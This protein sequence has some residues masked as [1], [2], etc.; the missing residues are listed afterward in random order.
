LTDQPA[1]EVAAPEAPPSAK[2]APPDFRAV[3]DASPQPLL[4]MAAD[5]PK[6]TMLAVN[7]AHARAF[8]TTPE[9]LLGW[10]VLEVFGEE[11]EPAIAPFVEAIRLSL[12]AV[13]ATRAP[14]QM[15]V[16]PYPV[17]TPD[18]EADE[19]YWSAVNAPVL[20]PD[21][22][23]IQI[24]SAVQDVTGEVLERRS[25]D[26]R[27]LLM[28]E[29]DHRARNALTVVQSFVR[30]TTAETLADFRKV[31]DGRVEALARAQTSLAARR[32]EGASLRDVIEGELAPL[33]E[34]D[35]YE[36][37]GP[38]VLLPPEH[39]QAMSMAIHELATNAAKYGALSTQ[40]GRL[41]A[42]WREDDARVVTVH[43]SEDGGPP[44][45]P[46]SREGFGSRLVAQLAKQMGGEVR[47]DWRPQGL[48]AELDC[49][50]A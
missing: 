8:A 17:T 42:G 20:G 45:Q 31:V 5:A 46:P 21:G 41:A 49:R 13:V 24:V 7:A 39:V 12:E 22:S 4:L 37:A 28:R 16:R 15:G 35:R 1:A 40:G 38:Q 6:F 33:A 48:R 2:L 9:A 26:A 43:W 19:R 29:V 30:L 18:G 25:E 3:F 32:W 27:N 50:L 10:G 36:L 14:D 47:Y 34:A 44:V 23:V 11:P